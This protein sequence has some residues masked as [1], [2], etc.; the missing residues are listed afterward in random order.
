MELKE[1]I[2]ESLIQISKAI[3]ESNEELKDTDAAINPG[4]IQI[5][6]ENS[7]AYGR[8]SYKAEHDELKVVHKIDFDVAVYAQDDQKAGGGAKISIASISM[9][10]DAEVKYSNKSE[11]RLRFSIPVIYPESDRKWR[12]KAN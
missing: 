3:E 7:Q 5:N 8:Q 12:N 4:C 1:F 10:T 2:K 9:G 11:S 6:S